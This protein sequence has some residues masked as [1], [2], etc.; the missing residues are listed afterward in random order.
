MLVDLVR[1]ET[2]DGCT[3]DGALQ[4]P[5]TGAAQL[6]LDAVVLVHGT[7]SNFYQS[8][9]LE[10][11]ANR[12]LAR[13]VAALRIN[14]RGHDGLSIA[15][16]ARGGVRQGAAYETV[17]DCRH[18][19]AGWM[20]FARAQVGPRVA[21]LGHSL[22]A[23]K[24]IYAAV[25]EASLKPALIIAVSPPRLSY[26]WFCKS[27]LG[28]AFLTT[29]RQ[30]EELVTAGQGAT[31][32]EA[33]VPLPMAISAAGFVDKYGPG[34]RINFLPLVPR[35][36]CPSLFT[37]G[38]REVETNVAFHELPTEVAVLTAHEQPRDLAVVEGADHF[39]T[40]K[41]AELATTVEGRLGRLLDRAEPTL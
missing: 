30:A 2:P 37:F 3:L 25:N 6:P 21:L 39:Y 11:L 17:D 32:I 28:E 40:G 19:L 22:G 8:T 31:L 38:S 13:G 27:A 34:E 33:T 26:A 24:C 4:H 20:N 16:T 12:F 41:R 14:T 35:L 23:V 15:V 10:F 36:P 5:A 1:I 29:Y 9:M 7:G 18:D